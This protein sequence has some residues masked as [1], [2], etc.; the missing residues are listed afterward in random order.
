MSDHVDNLIENKNILKEIQVIQLIVTDLTRFKDPNHVC[1]AGLTLDGQTCI[2][3][4][5][6]KGIGPS[7][8][9]LTYE[10]CKLDNIRPG[11]IIEAHFKD[12]CCKEDPHIEDQN[13]RTLR[14]VRR[15][16]SEEFEETLRR[17]ATRTLATGFGVPVLTKCIPVN[18]PT[19]LRSITTLE[20]TP[21]QLA[22]S[23]CFDK[24]RA[25]FTDGS[26]STFSNLSV[27]DLG[28]VD[29]FGSGKA[30]T[31]EL[32]NFLRRARAM[33]LRV[34]LSRPFSSTDGRSGYWLQVNGIYTFPDIP[35]GIR[36]FLR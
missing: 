14:V 26:G 2:R 17:S 5:K 20:I 27:T 3:P 16:T 29:Y 30:V 32:I 1:V 28:F 33:F 9:Y 18:G 8:P 13:Y 34:G 15:G 31:H 10:R 11:T 19:P 4:M 21:T 23:V 6:E 36:S 24:L 25:T 7:N 12:T 35:N 22:I